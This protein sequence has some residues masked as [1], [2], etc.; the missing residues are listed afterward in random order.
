MTPL[1][2][3]DPASMIESSDDARLVLADAVAT[4]DAGQI[5][6]AIGLVVRSGQ[7][8]DEDAHAFAYDALREKRIRDWRERD[9]KEEHDR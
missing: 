5:A 4:G 6:R 2:A 9:D 1:I 7:I 3:F 8:S